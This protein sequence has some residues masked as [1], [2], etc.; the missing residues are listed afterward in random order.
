VSEVQTSLLLVE[1][2]SVVIISFFLLVMIKGGLMAGGHG[3]PR[4]MKAVLQDVGIIAIASWIAE[5]SCIRLYKFYQYDAPWTFFVDVMPLMVVLI[6]PF[7]LLSAREVLHRLRLPQLSALFIMVLYDASLIEPIAVQAKLW[8]WNEPGLFDV[9]LI[10]I[11]GWAYFAAS[12]IL[13]LDRLPS[14]FRWMSIFI[15]PLATHIL[16]L[17]TW[18]GALRWI[19]RGS[20][21]PRLAVGLATTVALILGVITL[22]RRRRADLYVMAPRMAAAVLFFV[23]L[24][25]RGSNFLALVFYGLSFAVPYLIATRWRFEKFG[26][27][28]SERIESK[29]RAQGYQT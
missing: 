27:D 2:S 22:V 4:K 6:W 21:D 18:W 1:S 3:H 13:C 11:L 29:I 25:L 20:I 5:V 19:L 26:S 12:V 24:G 8:S 10:G 9:P 28:E 15:A 14:R 17:T 16:L 7:V 23:L